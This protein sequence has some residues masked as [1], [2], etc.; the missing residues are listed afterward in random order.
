MFES[1]RKRQKCVNNITMRFLLFII[2][3]CPYLN[4]LI[5][6][7]KDFSGGMQSAVLHRNKRVVIINY[8]N[9]RSCG[10]NTSFFLIKVLKRIRKSD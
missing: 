7:L 9:G 3:I 6:R 1:L 8:D 2:I 10:L 4:L 5:K